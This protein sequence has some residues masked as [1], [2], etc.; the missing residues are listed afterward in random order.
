[1][2]DFNGNDGENPYGAVVIDPTGNLYG[3]TA[4]GGR[5]ND[6]VIFEITP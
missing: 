5:H 4:G 6:G 2:H 1:L 3:T